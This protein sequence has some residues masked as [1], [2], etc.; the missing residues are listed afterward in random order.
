MKEPIY[1][2]AFCWMLYKCEHGHIM[3]IYNSR[4]GLVVDEILCPICGKGRAFSLGK[5]H[6]KYCPGYRLAHT[7]IYFRDITKQDYDEMIK[8]YPNK[9]KNTPFSEI[10]G[11]PMLA[12]HVDQSE[13]VTPATHM[14]EIIQIFETFD[15]AE[16]M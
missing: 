4:D 15:D 3:Q 14:Q 6:Y 11:F 12:V 1:N 13:L 2:S 7:D 5:A 8:R 16:L 10:A 9:Y